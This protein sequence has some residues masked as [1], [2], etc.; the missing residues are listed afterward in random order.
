MDASGW[1]CFRTI[2]G[3]AFVGLSLLARCLCAEVMDFNYLQAYVVCRII[4]LRKRP[5]VPPIRICEVVR[6][7]TVTA[8]LTVISDDI[9]Q[10]AAILQLCAGVAAVIEAAIY[11][12]LHI[13]TQQ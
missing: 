2:V 3:T 9:Q 4:L 6:I 5:G 11:A 13:Y 12:M 7:K 1:W 10:A 8:I